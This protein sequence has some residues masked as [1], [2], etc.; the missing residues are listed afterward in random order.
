MAPKSRVN[1]YYC[2]LCD[3]TLVPGANLEE[4]KV[5]AID[6]SLLEAYGKMTRC[7]LQM[8]REDSKVGRCKQKLPAK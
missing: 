1:S 2:E 8:F 3:M 7:Q 6:R 4:H 5:G